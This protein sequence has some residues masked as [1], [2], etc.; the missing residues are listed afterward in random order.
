VARKLGEEEQCAVPGPLGGEAG[1][2]KCR[3]LAEAL[4]GGGV[5]GVC[6]E[7]VFRNFREEI[8][9]GFVLVGVVEGSDPG[10]IDE[11]V[12]TS[13]GPDVGGEGAHRG[14]TPWA[15]DS[16]YLGVGGSLDV[17]DP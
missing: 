1:S 8:V 13:R 5:G 11:I 6:E 16:L 15:Q 17:E 2:G 12:A 14:R 3:G 10:A 4:R 7:V 9:P